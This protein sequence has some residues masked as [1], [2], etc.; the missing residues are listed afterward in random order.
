MVRNLPRFRE[1]R[2]TLDELQAR[3]ERIEEAHP[4]F[5]EALRHDAAD[6]RMHSADLAAEEEDT[7]EKE[8]ER[9]RKNEFF[10]QFAQPRLN[11]RVALMTFCA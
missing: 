1:R 8:D 7:D 5:A 4:R 11:R 10:H 3:G 2:R 6:D 9:R